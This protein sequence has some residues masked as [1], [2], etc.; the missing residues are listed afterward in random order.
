MMVMSGIKCM[1]KNQFPYTWEVSGKHLS[2]HPAATAPEV[3]Y[4]AEK[5]AHAQTGW[6]CVLLHLNLV[7]TDRQGPHSQSRESATRS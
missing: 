7:R 3:I 4:S 5:P 6:P 2:L 1:I